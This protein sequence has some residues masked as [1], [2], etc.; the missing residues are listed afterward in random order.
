MKNS[1]HLGKNSNSW[2]QG[3]LLLNFGGL[4]IRSVINL[5]SVAFLASIHSSIALIGCILSPLNNTFEIKYLSEALDCWKLLC[6]AIQIPDSPDLQRLWDASIINKKFHEILDFSDHL[7]KARLLAVSEL[8]S[9]AWLK[10]L[11]SSNLGT[12]LNTSNSCCS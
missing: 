12:L 6:P 9:G 11:T 3:S 10:A 8:K 2:N 1:I 4:G 7:N 5:S